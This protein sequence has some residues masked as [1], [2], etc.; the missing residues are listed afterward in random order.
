MITPAISVLSSVEG[1]ELAAPELQNL[2]LP[3]TVVILVALFWVQRHGTARIA[4]V[5][6]PI[7]L[8]WFLMIAAMGSPGSLGIRRCCPGSVHTTPSSFLSSA[9]CRGAR[10]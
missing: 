3:I 4:R 2:V 10:A 6:G 1:L 9:D 5:F 8:V 7:M